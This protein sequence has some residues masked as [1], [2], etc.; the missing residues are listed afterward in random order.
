MNPLHVWT[1]WEGPKLPYIEVCLKSVA[2]ACNVSG[3]EFHLVTPETLYQFIGKNTLHPNHNHLQL[4]MKAD[5]IRAALLAKYGGWWFDA[6]TIGLQS[7]L[8]I[9][10][11]HSDAEVLYMTWTRPPRRILNG[12]IYIAKGSSLAQKWLAKINYRLQHNFEK[13]NTW[14]GLGEK[15]LTPIVDGQGGC[16]EIKRSLFLPIDIDKSV[17]RFFKVIDFNKYLLKDTV[18]YGL[19]HSWFLSKQ[20]RALTLNPERWKSSPVLLHQLLHHISDRDKKNRTQLVKKPNR[21][22][23]RSTTTPSTVIVTLAIGKYWV[24]AKNLF[25]SLKNHGMPR[26]IARVVLSDDNIEPNFAERKPI[27]HDYDWI[28]TKEGQFASTANKLAALSLN[29]N[30]IIL[31]D[32]DIFCVKDCKFLWSDLLGELPFYAVADTAAIGY[33]P[34]KIQHL[35]LDENLIFNAGVMV[36]N[37]LVY[38]NLLQDLLQ[39]IKSG[40]CESY[41]GGDQGYLNS[42]FQN[43]NQEIGYLPPGYNYTADQHMPRVLTRSRFL[44]HFAGRAKPWD[45]NYK[46]NLG[47]HNTYIDQWKNIEV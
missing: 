29:Y 19:N 24:G 1:Y 47:E 44:F 2:C 3:V 31:I 18:C 10:N 17:P 39:D 40:D 13:A 15:L 27:G 43:R 36:Y 34:E 41:D 20:R 42:F 5:C 22:L 8:E 12:Y 11:K 9:T 7:P 26:E 21:N 23:L 6:D 35:G 38:P 37:R 4:A 14:L 25:Q 45:A 33:Y 32:S 28:K 46:K 30:R 16:V